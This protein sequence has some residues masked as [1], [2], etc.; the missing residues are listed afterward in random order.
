MLIFLS[1][2]ALQSFGGLG[3]VGSLPAPGSQQGTSPDAPGC[4]LLEVEGA[5]IDTPG[6]SRRG[7]EK[8]MLRLFMWRTTSLK[9]SDAVFQGLKPC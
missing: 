3:S 7:E 2:N 5:G 6:Q 1:E 4:T 9:L 8:R